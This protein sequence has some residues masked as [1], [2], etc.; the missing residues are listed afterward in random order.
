MVKLNEKCKHLSYFLFIILK[1]T[2]NQD[3][4]SL[5]ILYKA[6]F[7]ADLRERSPI[8]EGKWKPNDRRQ[9]EVDYGVSVR[10]YARQLTEL[11]E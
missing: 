7:V 6:Q 4:K 1:Y 10:P 3:K 2:Y 8:P 11:V 5:R 9:N